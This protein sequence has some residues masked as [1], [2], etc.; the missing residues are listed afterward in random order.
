MNLYSIKGQVSNVLKVGNEQTAK[1][2]DIV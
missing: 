1:F 2:S